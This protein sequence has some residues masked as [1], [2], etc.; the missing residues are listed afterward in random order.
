[1]SDKRLFVIE[2]EFASTLAVMKREGNTLSPIVRAAWDTGKLGMLTKNSPA[3]ATDALIS[4]TG[5]ITADEL[6]REL[7]RNS[8]GNGFAN[9]FLFACV[10]RGS[11]LPHGGDL[12]EVEI[13]KLGE[14]TGTV[15]EQASKVTRVRM[16]PAARD[17]WTAIYPKLSA[18]REGLLGALTARAEAQT[19]R[20]ALIYTLLD[21]KSEMDVVHLHAAEAVWAYCDASVQYVFGDSFGDPIADEILRSLRV[22][23]PDGMTRT[24][25]RDLFGRNRNA[26]QIGAALASLATHGRA[27]CQFR[28]TGG[29]PAELWSICTT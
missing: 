3:H 10:R 27:K 12:R 22:A 20:L 8:M 9:R 21:G 6:R 23:G 11:L 4:I 13:A 1:V 14:A 25:I 16:T 5:H 19:I 24:A 28:Q 7:D 26:N 15:I 29:K 17:H 2:A 18:E